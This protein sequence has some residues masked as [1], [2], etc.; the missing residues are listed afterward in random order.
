MSI[1]M[2]EISSVATIVD[3]PQIGVLGAETYH[4]NV[5]YVSIWLARKKMPRY[6]QAHEEKRTSAVAHFR[7]IRLKVVL[8]KSWLLDSC[9]VR[10]M[11]CSDPSFDC[12]MQVYRAGLPASTRN[13]D[14]DRV[15]AHGRTK[16]I[17]RAAPSC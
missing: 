16:Y 6:L 15:G 4:A 9:A 1:H 8:L 12:E 2:R 17:E 3:V 14:F 7:L 5:P 11:R 13:P 10:S